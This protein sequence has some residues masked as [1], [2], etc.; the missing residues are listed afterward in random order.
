MKKKTLE[1]ELQELCKHVR[2]EIEIWEYIN[3]NGCNDPFWAD[4]TNMNLTRNHIIY[5]K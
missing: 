4:G 1:Q 3:Q 5:D 2:Q